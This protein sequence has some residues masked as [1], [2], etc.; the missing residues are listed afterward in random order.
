MNAKGL[1][2]NTYLLL[3]AVP[4]MPKMASAK[5]LSDEV[6]VLKN[7]ISGAIASLPSTL[8]LCQEGRKISF[9]SK[10]AKKRVLDYYGEHEKWIYGT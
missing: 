4:V 7:K 1:N 9:I 2:S 10:E 3:A 8:P 6:P 5:E